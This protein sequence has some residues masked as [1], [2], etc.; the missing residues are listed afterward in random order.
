MS[1]KIEGAWKYRH[2]FLT[3]LNPFLVG[4]FEKLRCKKRERATTCCDDISNYEWPFFK[5]CKCCDRPEIGSLI[6]LVEG[7]PRILA[8][9]QNL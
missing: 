4:A 2:E 8:I 5:K 7:G 3:I 1:T 6:I 9:Y